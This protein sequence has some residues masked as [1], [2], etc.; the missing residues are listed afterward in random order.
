MGKPKVEK[1]KCAQCRVGWHDM[2]Q[3]GTCKCTHRTY[4]TYDSK[5]GRYVD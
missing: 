5:T 2:C 1:P 4:Q 3:R